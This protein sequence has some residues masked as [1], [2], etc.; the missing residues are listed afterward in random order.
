MPGVLA[1]SCKS[2]LKQHTQS[3]VAVA[4]VVNGAMPHMLKFCDSQ[5]FHFLRECSDVE[6]ITTSH[7]P[8]RPAAACRGA[9]HAKV[10]LP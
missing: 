7:G 3:I 5:T 10:V 1:A 9:I 4:M 8:A 6:I 2:N